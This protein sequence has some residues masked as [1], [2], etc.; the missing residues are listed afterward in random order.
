MKRFLGKAG[1]VCILTTLLFATAGTVRGEDAEGN[2]R[3]PLEEM[4]LEELRAYQSY[5]YLSGGRDPLT[6]RLPTEQEL[7][8]D[9][10]DGGGRAPTLE[11]MEAQL[12]LWLDLITKSIKSR[13][14]EAAIKIGEEA[15]FMIDN[16][17][18]AL[19]ADPPHLLRMDEEIRKYY[20]IATNLKNIEDI[21]KEF[22]SMNL[23]VDGV[24]WSPTDAKA[25]INGR[26]LSAGE[27]MIQERPQG[28]LRIEMIEEHGVVFQYKGQRF[29]LPVQLYAPVP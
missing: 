6:M 2:S 17:W 25:V 15:V 10:K 5:F 1:I 12:S 27:I 19:K 11:E 4:S 20:A 14:Y 16:E 18:P 13:D 26:L 22:D 23:R 7:G 3:K 28:D 29:H 21:K 8:L 24:A 9:D